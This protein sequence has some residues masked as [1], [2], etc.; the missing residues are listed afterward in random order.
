MKHMREQQDCIVIRK[1]SYHVLMKHIYHG[2]FLQKQQHY[3]ALQH[4]VMIRKNNGTEKL[5]ERCKYAAE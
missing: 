3:K 4:L 5:I 2:L 1:V